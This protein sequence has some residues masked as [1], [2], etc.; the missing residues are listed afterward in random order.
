MKKGALYSVGTWGTDA[1][2]FTPQAKLGLPWLNIPLWTLKRVL[3][4]LKTMGY[5][6]YRFG[7]P[8]FRDDDN[9][10]FVMVERTDGK[11][12]SAVLESWKR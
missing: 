12:K 4:R 3:Q 5:G 2:A 10:P 8:E 7:G 1:Q 6:C 9:D 11:S